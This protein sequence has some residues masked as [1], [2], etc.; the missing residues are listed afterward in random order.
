[1]IF[2]RPAVTI[3]TPPLRELVL[4]GQW[5]KAGHLSK[6]HRDLVICSLTSC[7]PIGADDGWFVCLSHGYPHAY[8]THADEGRNNQHRQ[9]DANQLLILISIDDLSQPKMISVSPVSRL[10]LS[11][12]RD[13]TFAVVKHIQGPGL[14]CCGTV[15]APVIS[16]RT[17]RY[18]SS[19]IRVVSFPKGATV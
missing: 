16:R 2:S 19:F 6:Y 8:P 3:P 18:V 12:E 5:V 7:R 14:R 4:D 10:M 9:H 13:E 1:V 11:A 15:E 17:R